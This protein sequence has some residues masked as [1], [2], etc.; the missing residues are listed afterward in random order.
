MHII[1]SFCSAFLMYSKIPVPQV[2]WKEENRRYALCFFPVIG[3]AIGV[4]LML[5]YWLCIVLG[6]GEFL[7]A[8]IAVAIPVIVTGGIHLDGFCDVCDAKACCGTKK[9]MLEVMSDSHIGAFAAINLALYFLIQAGFFSQ[10][11][12][13]DI[14]VI[15]SLGFIQSRAWSGLAAVTFKSAKSEGSLQNFSRPA[16]KSITISTEIF[17]LI[18]TSF[19]MIYTNR[20]CGICAVIGGIASF[21]YYRVFAYKKFGGITGD[22]AGY[23]L[24][25]CEFSIM[26]F[27]V[28]S[29][30]IK[31]A[32]F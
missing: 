19:A 26:A 1:K 2:E 25:I 23:F 18:I 14:M 9:K 10:I 24:Q 3:L 7:F 29:Y 8:A 22:L 21:V 20:I 6:T 13:V 5:W 16:H 4:A 30:L 11:K 31:E 15:C 28:L 12:S 27:A 32:F 17:F